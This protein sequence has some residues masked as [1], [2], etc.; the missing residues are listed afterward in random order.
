MENKKVDYTLISKCYDET[1]VPSQ[2]ILES[3][4]SKI[5]NLGKISTSLVVLDVGCGTG[6]YTIPIAKKTN[7]IVFGLD[8]SKEM[9]RRA[10]MKKDNQ[11]VEWLIGNAENLPFSNGHFDCVIMT[12]VIHQ[13]VN[14]KKAVD[15]VYRVLKKNGTFLVLTKSHGHLRRSLL[16]DFPKARQI[17]LKRFP[18]ILIIKHIMLSAGF[19]NAR[20]HVVFEGVTR[21]PM[22]DYLEKIRK[23]FIPTLTL[24]S[25][26]DF[27]K[28]LNIFERKLKEKIGKQDTGNEITFET[29]D[30][31]IVGE[32]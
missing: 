4:L 25:E 30:T 26:E 23:K 24:L 3:R 20:Y 1:R 10:K 31:F 12:T 21:V 6:I 22:E 13:I 18:T 27:Q 32:K 9:I 15:E 5:I 17:D 14:R 2:N 16:M 28:G 19:E 11:V 7:A 8:S 29:E